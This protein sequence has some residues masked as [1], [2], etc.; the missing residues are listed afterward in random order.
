ATRALT[1]YRPAPPRVVTVPKPIERT[2]KSFSFLDTADIQYL[3]DLT[4][5]IMRPPQR[6]E[7]ENL[8]LKGKRAF[9]I[10]FWRSRDPDLST[11][12]NEELDDALERF[13]YAN[14][15]FSYSSKLRDGWKSDRGRVIMKYGVPDN[16]INMPMPSISN[17]ITGFGAWE[18]WDYD[19]I[20]GGVYFIFSDEN[21]YGYYRLEHSNAK[22]ERFDRQLE[23]RINTIFRASGG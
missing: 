16:V 6:R 12:E 22:G 9:I 5:W 13:T 7:H 14:D 4:Y 10:E 21:G 20:Q 17:D 1:F 3:R 19:R 11:K 2:V 23:S 8:T 15:K 18:R